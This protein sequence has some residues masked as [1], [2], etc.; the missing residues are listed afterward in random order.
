MIIVLPNIESYDLFL[1]NQVQMKFIYVTSSNVELHNTIIIL[2]RKK[3]VK[4]FLKLII[5]QSN[6]C[7]PF[8]LIN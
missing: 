6:M 8:M 2:L 7:D 3:F 5:P 1:L 4:Y